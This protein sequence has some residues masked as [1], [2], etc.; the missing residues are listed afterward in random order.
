M[1]DL[2][3][4]PNLSCC[5]FERQKCATSDLQ[6]SWETLLLDRQPSQKGREDELDEECM[7]TFPNCHIST[8]FL[9]CLRN[10]LLTRHLPKKRKWDLS[11]ARNWEQLPGSTWSQ[12]APTW[13]VHRTTLHLGESVKWFTRR[14]QKSES[15]YN[16]GDGGSSFLRFQW[17]FGVFWEGGQKNTYYL[18]TTYWS[19]F[20]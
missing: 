1:L 8:E 20:S 9:S 7:I 18:G 11:R 6:R 4:L 16:Y 13:P 19:N 3:V 14:C 5:P 2:L 15:L 10:C 17:R 12:P